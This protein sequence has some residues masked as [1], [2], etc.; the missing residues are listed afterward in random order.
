MP[1]FPELCEPKSF[2][3]DEQAAIDELKCLFATRN[4]IS[5]QRDDYFLTKFLRFCDWNA[6]K[7][8]IYIVNFYELKHLNPQHYAQKN[9]SEYIDILSTNSRVLL[10][11]RDKCG[12]TV[13][14]GKL[15]KK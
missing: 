15:G 4:D 13:F 7:A 1:E 10:D 2:T 3:V 5:F 8:F 11:K 6:E 14:V 12:R 9:V